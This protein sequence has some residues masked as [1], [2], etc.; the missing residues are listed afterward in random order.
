GQGGFTGKEKRVVFTM[1]PNRLGAVVRDIVK[2]EDPV[3]FMV[4][5]SAN[6]IFG[7]GYKDIFKEEI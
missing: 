3:A 4:V 7:E 1:V 5:T 2:H 6:E